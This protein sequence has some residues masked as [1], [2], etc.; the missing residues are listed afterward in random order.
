MEDGA[1]VEEHQGCIFDC[2]VWESFGCKKQVLELKKG[3]SHKDAGYFTE[4]RTGNTLDS[5]TE[6]EPF[7]PS[8][9]ACHCVY[10][11]A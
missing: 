8:P 11:H 4:P 2:P 10:W 7:A 9:F 6:L 1:I 3:G 5:R